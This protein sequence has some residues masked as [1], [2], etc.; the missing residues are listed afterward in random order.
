MTKPTATQQKQIGTI[1]AA[2]QRTIKR[3]VLSGGGAK[4]IVY[5]GAYRALLKSGVLAQVSDVAGSSAGAITAALIAVGAP[6]ETIRKDATTRSIAS[7]LGSRVKHSGIGII[8]PITKD[9]KILYNFIQDQISIALSTIAIDDLESKLTTLNKNMKR[10]GRELLTTVKSSKNIT[11]AQLN[12]LQQLYPKRFKN[13]TVTAVEYPSTR[14][15]LFNYK[16]TPNVSVALACRASASI[17]VG[18]QPV[19]IEI[20][21]RKC[22]YMDGGIENN[23]PTNT[24]SDPMH[25]EETLVFAFGE[26][27]KADIYFGTDRVE[28]AMH[29]SH[30]SETIEFELLEELY[31][32][33]LETP[34]SKTL[35]SIENALLNILKQRELLDYTNPQYLSPHTTPKLQ[36]YLLAALHDVYKTTSSN[37]P[38]ASELTTA[39]WTLIKNIKRPIYKPHIAEYVVQ[40]ILPKYLIGLE[41]PV[42]STDRKYEDFRRIRDYFPLRTV[43]LHVGPISSVDFNKATKLARVMD[44]IGYADT[45]GHVLNYDLAKDFASDGYYQQVAHDFVIIY[46]ALLLGMSKQPE[47]DSFLT[48]WNTLPSGNNQFEA[49]KSY[50]I[51][52]TDSPVAF[53]FTRAVEYKDRLIDKNTLL[54]E[55]YVEAFRRKWFAKSSSLGP[56]FFRTASLE[57]ALEKNPALIPSIDSIISQPRSTKRLNSIAHELNLLE[58][59]EIID[60]KIE[61]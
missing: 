14:V 26:G 2:Q 51:K 7:F 22:F 60:L 23:L 57:Q 18:L 5:P 28:H 55:T 39:C 34:K 32:K 6:I 33:A 25:Y 40:N 9:G 45:I 43:N 11:F 47:N 58:E 59:Q 19:E 61:L 17:P 15:Q 37:P 20:N 49:I 35:K 48:H 21:G 3:I 44:A 41:M 24:I 46:R 31:S 54:K 12:L 50:V 8:R 10:L 13:L 29:R 1:L 16:Q 4:G 38:A 56:T 52:N 30:W 36:K 27:N 53:A 42:L